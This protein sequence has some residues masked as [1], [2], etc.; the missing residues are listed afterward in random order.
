MSSTLMIKT[1]VLYKIAAHCLAG[2]PIHTPLLDILLSQNAKINQQDK[3]GNTELHLI[4]RN[5]RQVQAA[6]WLISRGEDVS[7]TNDKGNTALHECLRMEI[8]LQRQTSKGIVSPTLAGRRRALDKMVVVLLE[9][10]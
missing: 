3:D 7:L 4:A 1:Y 10:G 6:R 8:I 2:E 5:L 9:R